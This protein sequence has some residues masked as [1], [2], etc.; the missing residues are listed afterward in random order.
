MR[1]GN[2]P[3]GRLFLASLLLVRPMEAKRRGRKLV[4]QSLVCTSF[5]KTLR[6][7]KYLWT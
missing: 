4:S 5:R 1:N 7:L 6:A 3:V 2:V